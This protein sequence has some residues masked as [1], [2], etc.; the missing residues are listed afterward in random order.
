MSQLPRIRGSA[1]ATSAS[2]ESSNASSESTT[3]VP[4]KNYRGAQQGSSSGSLPLA[5][6]R[7]ANK[8]RTHP[9]RLYDNPPATYRGAQQKLPGC[10]TSTTGVSNKYY[11]GAQQKLPGC[12]ASTT[13]VPDKNYR[14][15]QQVVL[16]KIAAKRGF[17]C[18]V[19]G[20]LCFCFSCNVM[21]LNN[22][23][24]ENGEVYPWGPITSS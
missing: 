8:P 7:R 3:G 15:A 11:R 23:Y 21:L 24:S 5:P 19:S 1:P 16:S 14:G 4:N 10:P 13:G 9:T 2:P 12:P 6:L 18:R 17:L 20:P 22:N